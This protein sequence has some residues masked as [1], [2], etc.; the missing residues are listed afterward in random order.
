[1]ALGQ[2]IGFELKQVGAVLV[3]IERNVDH[4]GWWWAACSKLP[5]VAL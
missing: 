3:M 2:Q 1:M 5:M 4:V